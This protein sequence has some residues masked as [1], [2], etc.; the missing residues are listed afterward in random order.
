MT[1]PS[2]SRRYNEKEVALI[3][4]QASELQESSP[5][6]SSA[7]MSLVE[8]EQIARETGLDPALIRR[9]A[10]DIDTRVTDKTPSRFLGAPSTLRLERTIDGEISPDEYEP[11]VLEIQRIVGAMGAASTLGRSLQW[12]ATSSGRRRISGRMVQVTITPKNG[13]TTIR[14]EEPVSQVATGL[15][16]GSMGGI[17]MGMMPLVSVAG[18]AVGASVAGQP[19]AIAAAIATGA[20]FLGAT[21]LAAR[22]L[23][24]RIVARRGE[25]LQT[26]MSRLAE[27]V[28]ATAIKPK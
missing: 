11:I 24:G 16:L 26:L 23:F 14:I 18:G 27:H 6:D 9:A 13:R 1:E 3:I 2:S 8:L 21:Y 20:A 10:A 17:G 12:T 19:A 7:G 15:F 4:K 22:T 25:T 28:S 5:G